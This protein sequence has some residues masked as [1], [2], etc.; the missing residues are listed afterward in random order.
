[1]YKEASKQ[2]LRFSTS[3]GTVAVEQLWE[4]SLTEL[5]NLVLSLEEDYKDSGKK[6]YIYKKSPKDRT[7]KLKFDIALDILTTM[8]EESEALKNAKEIKEHNQKI[9]GLIADKQEDALKGKSVEELEKM[10]K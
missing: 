10:L 3:K 4:L 2:K 8:F 7:N 6:S 5:D 1:M 9:L